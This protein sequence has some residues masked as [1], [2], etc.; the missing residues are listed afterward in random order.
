MKIGLTGNLTIIMVKR[1]A[2]I[3]LRF[4]IPRQQEGGMTTPVD[5]IMIYLYIALLFFARGL[6]HDKG[7]V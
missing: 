7:E 6:S 1:N 5:A 2:S 3:C 4:T